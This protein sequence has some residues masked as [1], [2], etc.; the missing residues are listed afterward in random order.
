MEEEKI[1]TDKIY[2]MRFCSICNKSTH[3]VPQRKGALTY[4]VCVKC[5][6]GDK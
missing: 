1:V 5:G 3:H 2:L 4:L 6:K